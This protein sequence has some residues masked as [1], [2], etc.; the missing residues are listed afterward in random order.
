MSSTNNPEELRDS[1]AER[2]RN[3]AVGVY[4]AVGEVL[5][6]EASQ[7]MDR[8]FD[9]TNVRLQKDRE[10]KAHSL[11]NEIESDAQQ[12]ERNLKVIKLVQG[13][14]AYSRQKEEYANQALKAA[15]AVQVDFKQ[16]LATFEAAGIDSFDDSA[17]LV[18]KKM[19]ADLMAAQ[20]YLA[21]LE[22]LENL[23]NRS[24][25]LRASKGGYS[26]IKP[27]SQKEEHQLLRVIVKSF[28]YNDFSSL[29]KVKRGSP[30]QIVELAHAWAERI[31]AVNNELKFLTIHAQDELKEHVHTLLIERFK[32]DKD[33][34]SRMASSY[35]SPRRIQEIREMFEALRT[36]KTQQIDAEISRNQGRIEG[37]QLALVHQ[38]QVKFGELDDLQM[39]KIR[40]INEMEALSLCFERLG[41]ASLLEDVLET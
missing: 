17:Y 39:N 7:L 8:V 15:V 37:L 12:Y 5:F 16:R 24:F 36:D 33:F 21:A 31:Y 3:R 19:L 38:L 2:V 18:Y 13:E 25:G 11:F 34:L 6:N 30:K 23:S 28:F 35:Q 26:Q 10:S 29:K 20:R 4:R 22:I 14:K 40:L 32:I 27:P 9:L 1:R 41:D